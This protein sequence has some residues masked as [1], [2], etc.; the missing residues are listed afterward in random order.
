MNIE[1]PEIRS[2]IWAGLL[3]TDGLARYY[4]CLAERYST[5]NRWALV[6]IAIVSAAAVV[7]AV[8]GWCLWFG[9]GLSSIAATLALAVSYADYSRRA[10]TAAFIGGACIEY[11][12]EWEH[13]WHF[14]DQSEE[15]V[16]IRRIRELDQQVNRTTTIALQQHG[17]WDKKLQERCESEANEYWEKT[18]AAE[19]TEGTQ[20]RDKGLPTP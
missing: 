18:Y 13:L 2:R 20:H 19:G 3:S 5:R 6:T 9:V 7:V 11:T 15:S 17:F 1:N 16:V 8:A 4:S 12:S 14:A 10:G